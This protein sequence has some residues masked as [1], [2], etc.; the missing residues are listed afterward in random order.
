MPLPP[1]LPFPETKL[2]FFIVSIL[3]P[4]GITFW[5]H[6]EGLPFQQSSDLVRMRL[7]LYPPRRLGHD[8]H[9]YLF[10]HLFY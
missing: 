8:S 10:P 3:V 4:S 5:V 6:S 7:W 9:I 1:P 2:L